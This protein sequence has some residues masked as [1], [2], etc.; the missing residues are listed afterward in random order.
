[1]EDL[2]DLTESTR[3]EEEDIRSEKRSSKSER[4]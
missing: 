2:K 4:S 3:A 1:M